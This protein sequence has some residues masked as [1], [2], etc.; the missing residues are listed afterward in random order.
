LGVIV[1]LAGLAAV[2]QDLFDAAA[3]D[4]AV[5]WAR[6]WYVVIP[7][8]RHVLEFWG[9]NLVVWSFTSLFAFVYVMTAGGPGY[10]TM[11]VEYQ[12]YQQAFEFNRMGYACALGT[13]LF[14]L[15]F[16]LVLVQVRLMAGEE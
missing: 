9:V 4:G 14:L 1:F 2:P 5:G 16:G 6:L 10:A 11:L 15:V 8:L 13:F 7:A 12:V 3:M